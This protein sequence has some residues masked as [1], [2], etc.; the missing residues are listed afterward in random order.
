[1]RL[2]ID[3]DNQYIKHNLIINEAVLSEIIAGLIGDDYF[4]IKNGIKHI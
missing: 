2:N 1:M 3:I 4:W